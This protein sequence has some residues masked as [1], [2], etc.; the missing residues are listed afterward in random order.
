MDTKKIRNCL[1]GGA[2]GNALGAPVETMSRESIRRKFGPD[3]LTDYAPAFGRLGAIASDTQMT[4]FVAESLIRALVRYSHNGI[5][6]VDCVTKFAFL[7]WLYTQEHQGPPDNP[8][9]WLASVPGLYQRR[10]PSLSIIKALKELHSHPKNNSKG[11]GAVARSAPYGL[12]VID[13]FGR[14]ASG[15]M[16]THGHLTGQLS[17][18]VLAAL[19]KQ[20]LAGETLTDAANIAIEELKRHIGHQETLSSLELALNLAKDG[21]LAQNKAVDRIGQGSMAHEV[22]AIAVYCSLVARNFCEGVL[23]AVNHD[24]NSAATGAICGN[25][26]GLVHGLENIPPNWLSSLELRDVISELAE[27]LANSVDWNLGSY[28]T[29][30]DDK[31]VSK[32]YPGD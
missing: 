27:D 19:I 11:C 16:I 3:G 5:V 20:L 21:S 8:S 31:W 13:A 15:A 10:E 30:S 1:L 24:G 14:A 23:L 26:L 9:G 6:S 18:G 25:I 17:A 4:L 32:K 29:H 12:Y 22:L 7:R 2:I 28:S